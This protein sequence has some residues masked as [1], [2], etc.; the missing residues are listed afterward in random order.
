MEAGTLAAGGESLAD[1]IREAARRRPALVA[2]AILAAAVLAMVVAKGLHDV[3]QTGLTGLSLGAIYALGAVGLTLVYGI[4]KLVNFAAG[5][6][7]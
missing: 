4:L 7:G 5:A 3:A 6:S 2:V 1:R